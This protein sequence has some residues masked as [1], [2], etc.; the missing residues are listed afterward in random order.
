MAATIQSV[1]PVLMSSDLRR[2]MDFYAMLGFTV[3]FQDDKDQPRYAAITRDR[4]LLF[5]QWQSEEQWSA[6]IDR[7]T[8]RFF[9][10][11][12]DE[13]FREFEKTRPVAKEST[14]AGPW[15]KPGDT[16]WNTREFHILDPD[17]NGLQ[18]YRTL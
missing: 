16:P 1:H 14:G 4:V 9:V 5:L 12:P 6:P 17:G 7:P 2:S 10:S 18:F 13:L 8:Y 3:T 15:A 11:D